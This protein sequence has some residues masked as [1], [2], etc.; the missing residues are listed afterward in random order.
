MRKRNYTKTYRRRKS[1][2]GKKLLIGAAILVGFYLFIS[3]LFG[4][5]GVIKYY[6]MKAQHDQLM[7]RIADLK[8]NNVRLLQEVKSLK[9]DPAYIEKRAR[10]MLGLARPGEIIYYY[11]EPTRKRSER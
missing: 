8:Q 3:L 11:G 10:D 6:R 4:E 1:A 7:E 5:M 2:K 9:T